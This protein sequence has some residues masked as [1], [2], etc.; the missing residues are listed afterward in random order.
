MLVV[1]EA[2]ANG[3]ESE[4]ARSRLGNRLALPIFRG[5]ALVALLP[6]PPWGTGLR[7]P[8]TAFMVVLSSSLLRSLCGSRLLPSWA[9]EGLCVCCRLTR[10]G[11]SRPERA[12]ASAA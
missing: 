4:L 1:D 7:E 6:P 12:K 10:N 9:N 2:V 5:D 8:E 3:C 11:P